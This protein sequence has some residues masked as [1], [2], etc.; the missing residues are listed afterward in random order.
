MRRM[1]TQYLPTM[2]AEVG[3]VLAAALN[4]VNQGRVR[5]SLPA[6]HVLTL[7]NLHQMTV[8]RT[9]FIFVSVPDVR[10][11]EEVA[12]DT[13]AVAGRVLNIFAG[14][15]LSDPTMVALFDQVLTYRNA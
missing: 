7:D 3:M 11:D 6:G 1:R 5:F 10:S 14:A 13:A 4:V 2:S 15:D 8:N 12:R 9:E